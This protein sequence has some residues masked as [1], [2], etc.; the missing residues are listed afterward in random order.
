VRV[1][2]RIIL[3]LGG[4]L[5]LGAMGGWYVGYAMGATRALAQAGGIGA[6]RSEGAPQG[7][8]SGA[9][10]AAGPGPGAAQT[11]MPGAAQAA[12]PAMPPGRP[13][14]DPVAL[15]NRILAERQAVAADPGNLEA[16]AALGNDL[17]DAGQFQGSVEAYQK[18]LDRDPDN[19]NLLTDQGVMYRHLGRFDKAVA[20]FL[21]ASRADPR[22]L[23]SQYNLGVVYAEDFHDAPK[24]LKAYRRVLEID[25][26]AP[27][28]QLAREAIARLQAR[29]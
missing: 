15:Q 26:T 12:G 21:R 14:Q 3:A 17:F 19:P 22:H 27:Q 23:Q 16:W 8:M 25:P 18:V 11:V 29:P 24:A 20:N 1:D 28:A 5:V 9:P 6:A 13:V 10:G 2:K 7:A 4:G